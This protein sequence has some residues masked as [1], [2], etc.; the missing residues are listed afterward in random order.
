[1]RRDPTQG[2]Q[3]RPD[4]NRVTVYRTLSLLKRQALVDEL[5]LLHVKGRALYE[6]CPQRDHAMTCLRCG[7][8]QGL[9]TRLIA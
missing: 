5:D 6:R 2:R 8:V 1:M 7:K 3:G 9:V 4:I